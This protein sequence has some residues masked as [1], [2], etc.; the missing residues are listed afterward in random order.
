VLWCDEL[1]S[2]CDTCSKDVGM[3]SRIGIC[4]QGVHKV[5]LKEFS[6]KVGGSRGG[7]GSSLTKGPRVILELYIK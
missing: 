6:G 5:L 3:G 2:G 1:C 4:A 7:L